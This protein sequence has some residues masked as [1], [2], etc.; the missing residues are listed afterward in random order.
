MVQRTASLTVIALLAACVMPALAQQSLGDFVSNNG[1]DWVIGRWVA[2]TDQGQVELNYRWALDKYVVLGEVK[3][4]NYQY[5]GIIML[6]PGRGEVVERGADNRGGTAKGEWTEEYGD[7]VH[8]IQHTGPNG[9]VMKAQI[10]YTK[11]DADSVTIAMYRVDSSGYRSGEP[12]AKATYKRQPAATT[13]AA[14]ATQAGPTAD[15]EKLG[16]LISQG[17]YD[18]MAGKWLSTDGDQRYELE[19]KWALDKHVVL[20]DLKMAGFAY[21]GMIMYS[22]AT[23]EIFQVGADNLGGLWKGTWDQSYDGVTH[24]VEY[25][26]ADGA[27]RRM[28]HVY[29]QDSSDAFQVKEYAVTTGSRASQPGRTLIFK[30]Q[31]ASS[32]GK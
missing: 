23:R 2:T 6:D 17:G 22:P 14:T 31:T 20:M 8:R 28:E 9:E 11:V 1:Y 5:R 26:Q 16:D 25:T 27:V 29:V 13:D 21:H 19:H 12:M 15:Y 10:E 24:R 7:L 4:G 30:R 32:A 3:M 18:W